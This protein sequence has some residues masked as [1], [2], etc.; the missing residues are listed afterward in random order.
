MNGKKKSATVAFVTDFD[1][2]MEHEMSKYVVSAMLRDDAKCSRIELARALKCMA[3]GIYLDFSALPAAD[4]IK[5][6]DIL[7]D[8][9]SLHVEYYNQ[10]DTQ[11]LIECAYLVCTV[12]QIFNEWGLE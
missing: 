7:M 11:D 2:E 1:I 4:L 6:V 12:T 9:G 5:T 8:G 3:S 10:L